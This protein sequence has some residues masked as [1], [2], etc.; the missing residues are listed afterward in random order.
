MLAEKTII[1]TPCG[2]HDGLEVKNLND[3]VIISIMRSADIL[4]KCFKRL[5]PSVKI[6]KVLI[7][8]DEK[9]KE[10]KP[11]F[12]Y[13]KLPKLDQNTKVILCDPMLATGGS[14]AC[15]IDLL[16][17]ANVKEEN[18]LFVNVVCCPEGIKYLEEKFPKVSILTASVDSH[19]NE[20]KYIVPG[21]GDFGDRYYGT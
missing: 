10:K 2:T 18:I 12:Y 5:E 21:L 6:G 20:D 1:E 17:K 13:S 14:A 4:V 11:K 15:A 16:L 9:D 3:I 7:Q 8:R 19:L